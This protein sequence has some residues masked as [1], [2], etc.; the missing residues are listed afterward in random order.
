MRA[1][2][3]VRHRLAEVVQERGALRRLDA[4]AE[5]ARHDPREVDDLERVLEDVLAVARAIAEPP[6]HL[7]QLLVHVAA[8]RL[9]HGLLAGLADVLL[10]LGLRGVVGV[11]DP[12]RMNAAVLDQLLQRHPRQLA[13]D[14]VERG[15]HDRL[16]RVVDDEVDARQVLERADVAP[17]AADDAALHVIGR[18]LDHRDRRL[19]R[20]AGGDALERVRHEIARAPA[21]LAPR[22]LLEL[23]RRA[24]ELV[25]DQVLRALEQ[26]RLR[27]DDGEARDPLEL[28]HGLVLR[29]L[30]LLLE[31]AHVRLA[32]REPLLAAR[33]LLVAPRDLLLRGLRALVDLRD[34]G[35]AVGDLLLD[36]RAQPDGLLACLDLPLAPDRLRL[37]RG[38]ADA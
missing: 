38:D 34:L 12:R 14:A 8:V 6:E 15:E 13:A 3:L 22:L 37:A 35:A 32:V 29:G 11:L 10:E 25:P 31:L 36:L 16:R 7:R 1:V 24:G 5:L 26:V 17:L 9:E 30:Q 33:D 2:D 18:Q 4:R 23:A 20:V 28:L 21:R 27:L 19:G